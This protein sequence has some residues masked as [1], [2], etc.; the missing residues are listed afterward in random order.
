LQAV[1]FLLSVFFLS[2]P[3]G[4]AD[5][6][7]PSNFANLYWAN[8]VA[9][10]KDRVLVTLYCGNPRTI[11]SIDSSG[12]ATPFANLPNWPDGGCHEDYLAVS[13]GMGGFPAN[14]VYVAQGPRIYQVSADG[15]SVSLFLTLP[16]PNT[17]NAIAFD[18]VGTFGNDMIVTGSNGA[19]YKVTSAGVATLVANIGTMI[20][21]PVVAP[22]S[23]APYGGQIIVAA[24]GVSRVYAVS[25][26]GVV[27]HI[28][29]WP[30]AEA[31]HVI[32]QTVC[33]FG[34]SG[35][36]LFATDFPN[37]VEKYP[38]S[39]FT[40]LAG[41]LLVTGENGGIGLMTSNGA[42]IVMTTFNTDGTHYEGSAFVD[43][44]VPLINCSINDPSL[45]WEAPL[46][47]N[48]VDILPNEQTLPIRFYYGTCT[49]FNHDESVVVQVVNRNNPNI[50]YSADVYQ[51]FVD[52]A[53]AAKQYKLD[54][55]SSLYGLPNGTQLMVQ[56]FIGGELVG[57]APVDIQ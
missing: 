8:G 41:R 7:N 39:D 21:G 56:V 52:I 46:D 36:A 54:W 15:S 42:S 10:T 53:D 30:A 38:V 31:V 33:S 34:N 43:C 3:V 47:N 19:I 44:A 17:H 4:V 20:E 13:P 57:Q 29:D 37:G 35:G 18:E 55:D 25:N 26:T 22:P 5:A 32:P 23:F 28:A 45:Q 1:L 2:L 9:A 11:Y 40:G 50:V 14:Y 24:E 51:W 12:N 6:G 27:T 48:V 49:N 16:L